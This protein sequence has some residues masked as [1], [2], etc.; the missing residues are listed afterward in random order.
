MNYSPVFLKGGQKQAFKSLLVIFVV[1]SVEILFCYKLMIVRRKFEH[2]NNF[3]LL[4]FN[5]SINV[6]HMIEYGIIIRTLCL[7]Y[8]Q[9]NCEYFL[10]LIILYLQKINMK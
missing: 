4:L 10:S 2:V 5:M 9:E 3:F 1:E 6:G 8:S 7:Q